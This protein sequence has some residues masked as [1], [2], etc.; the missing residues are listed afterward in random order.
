M[1]WHEGNTCNAAPPPPRISTSVP[2]QIR[3][4]PAC[5]SK[6]LTISCTV[7]RCSFPEPHPYPLP[8][9]VGG[10]PGRLFD[11]SWW[12]MSLGPWTD[13]PLP[14]VCLCDRGNEPSITQQNSRSRGSNISFSVTTN[15][16]ENILTKGC[17]FFYTHTSF[18]TLLPQ[19]SKLLKK[20]RS[21]KNNSS[22]ADSLL[23]GSC[24]N[25]ETR[26]IYPGRC[27]NENKKPVST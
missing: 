20:T 12:W 18:L 14:A 21:G 1:P 9:S 17:H 8:Q 24:T 5:S 13:L 19:T 23:C 10:A 16:A 2:L 7:P 15:Q 6:H 4:I 22:E 27:N 25:R 3:S 11:D 26:C